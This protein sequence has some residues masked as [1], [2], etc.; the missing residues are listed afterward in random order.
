MGRDWCISINDAGLDD[1]DLTRHWR[2]GGTPEAFVAWFAEKYDL[3]RF[4]PS[5]PPSRAA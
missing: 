2:D 5:L 3:I 1:E 4:E